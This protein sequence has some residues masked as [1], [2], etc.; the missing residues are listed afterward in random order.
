MTALEA[1][2]I[3]SSF[4]V[5]NSYNVKQAENK[6]KTAA[7]QGQ[8]ITYLSSGSLTNAEGCYLRENGYGVNFMERITI[9]W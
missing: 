9:T 1:M 5:A 8:R 3:A 2:G 4:T 7:S 6:I